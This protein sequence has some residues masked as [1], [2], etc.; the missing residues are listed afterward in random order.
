MQYQTKPTILIA[1]ANAQNRKT[2]SA[3]LSEEY[4]ILEAEHGLQVLQLLEKRPI[5]AVLY[6]YALPGLTAKE[7]LML[8][9]NNPSLEKIPTFVIADQQESARITEFNP[10]FLLFRP[11]ERKVVTCPTAKDRWA[12]CFTEDCL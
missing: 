5:G 7:F 11:F 12:S 10:T 9:Q 3:Q 4:T 8:R 6:D 1:D 2:L